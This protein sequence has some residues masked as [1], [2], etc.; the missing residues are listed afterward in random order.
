MVYEAFLELIIQKLQEALGEDY[1]FTLRPLP[2]N[3]GVVLDGLTI[4]GPGAAL[5]PTVYLNP[6]YRQFSDGTALEQILE[7]ILQ[8]YRSTPVPE[9]VTEERIRNFDAIKDR[10]MFRLVHTASNRTLLS[11]VPH[12]PFL[13]LS[14]IFFLALER[15]DSGQITAL[16]HNGHMK[17]WNTSPEKLWQ[18]AEHNTP[19]EYPASIRSMPE[20][21]R[22]I[23]RSQMGSRYDESEIV[24]LLAQDEEEAIP[25]YVLSNDSGLYGA[26]CIIY[27]D[28]LKDFADQLER[29][30]IILP[31]SV[32]EVL[33]T[34]DTDLTDYN[35]LSAMVFSI[36]R[37]EVPLEDQLS[38]QV[39]LYSRSDRS[40][41]VMSHGSEAVGAAALS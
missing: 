32:H 23:A 34:P 2:K 7:D 24:E 30:L 20:L 13:D 25:L 27:Q 14:I 15:R 5:T 22:E 3:N 16:I 36:N 4:Q 6:Y 18:L 26:S 12:I 8:L 33:I 21:V 29:D 41:H 19:A 35:E 28:I 10:V 9:P 17:M 39:Y 38:N 40:I 37:H 31:S 11:D 1:Q